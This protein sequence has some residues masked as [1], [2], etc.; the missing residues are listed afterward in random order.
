M[1]SFAARRGFTI[2]E[3]IVTASIIAVISLLVVVNFRNY[4]QKSSLDHETERL[5]SILRQANIHA[6]TGMIVN[7]VRPAG[8]GLHLSNCH[9]HCS[10]FIFA[11]IDGDYIYSNGVDTIAQRLGVIEDNI[12]MTSFTPDNG[13]GYLDVTFSTPRGDIYFNGEQTA[14]EGIISLSYY[15]SS[16]QSNVTVN[17]FSGSIN[18]E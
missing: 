16:Y 10:Y 12:S 3:L 17:R 8:F 5:S 11:D 6:L 7:G 9:S 2:I 14:D 1:S 18:I 4:S 15:N 13:L